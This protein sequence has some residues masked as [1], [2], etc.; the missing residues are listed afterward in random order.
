MSVRCREKFGWIVGFFVLCACR[1]QQPTEILVRVEAIAFD[2]ASQSPVVVLQEEKGERRLPIWIGPAEAQAIALQLE[3]I[4]PPRPLTHDLLKAVLEGTGA[5]VEKVVVTE[6]REGIYYARIFVRSGRQTVALDSRPSDAIALAIRVKSPI[7][8]AP[9]VF[10]A[11]QQA[12]GQDG[13]QQDLRVENAQFRYR[14]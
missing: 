12:P 6:L 10:A 9:A 4:T 7:Y 1:S 8:V 5:S 14:S 11:S 13:P 2:R 3:R